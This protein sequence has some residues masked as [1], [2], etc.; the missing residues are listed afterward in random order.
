MSAWPWGR[1]TPS[2]AVPLRC[3]PR[4]RGRV[5]RRRCA[6]GSTRQG[7]AGYRVVANDVNLRSQDADIAA[8][9]LDA[10]VRTRVAHDAPDRVF[11]HAGVVAQ[12]GRAI[13]L[14]GRSMSGKTT[15]VAEPCVAAPPTTPRSTPL[16]T[17]T[18]SFIPIPSRSRSGPTGPTCPSRASAASR[19]QNRFAPGS[20]CS[21]PTPRERSGTRR[22]C[23]PR[24]G[25]SS[26]FPTHSSARRPGEAM[27]AATR[28]AK[29]TLVFEGERGEA[30]GVAAWLLAALER[31]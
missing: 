8:G 16:S 11:V 31:A 12:R 21:A 23:P 20:S 15:L 24:R 29:G 6:H 10:L 17:A 3:S 25:R 22:P 28:L 18:A 30:A 14:P 1:P 9:L 7:R 26:C 19:A 27:A 4:V 5:I 13:V 2:L